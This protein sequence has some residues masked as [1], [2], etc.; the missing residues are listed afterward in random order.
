MESL[1]I[2]V[3]EFTTAMTTEM[4]LLSLFKIEYA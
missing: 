4:I 2:K 1:T 3:L